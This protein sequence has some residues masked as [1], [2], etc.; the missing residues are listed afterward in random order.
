MEGEIKKGKL[1]G[2]VK[3][4]KNDFEFDGEYL[5]DLEWEGKI[6]KNKSNYIVDGE[7]KNYKFS[8][9]VRQKNENGEFTDKIY[10]NGKLWTWIKS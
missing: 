8:G 9:K 5:Y 2:K 4:S 1:N 3:I 6:K 7:F 10:L